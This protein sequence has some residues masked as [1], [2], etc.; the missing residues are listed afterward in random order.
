MFVYRGA[1]QRAMGIDLGYHL[2]EL[3][4]IPEASHV[5]CTCC[6]SMCLANVMNSRGYATVEDAAVVCSQLVG[7]LLEDVW[8]PELFVLKAVAQR[9]WQGTWQVAC[10][11]RSH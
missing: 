6:R 3:V 4:Y 1:M 9:R 2:N 11:D 5:V 8:T 10:H 7:L